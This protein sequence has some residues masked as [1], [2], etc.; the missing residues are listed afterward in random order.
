MLDWNSIFYYKDGQ[1]FWKESRRTNAKKDKRAGYSKQ[2]GYRDIRAFNRTIK[3]HRVVWELHNGAI[4]EGLFVDHINRN[5]SDNRIENLRLATVQE[6]SWNRS[7]HKNNTTG[8]PN[9]H[10]AKGKFVATIRIG[11]GQRLRSPGFESSEEAI[12]WLKDKNETF[13]KNLSEINAS[14][15]LTG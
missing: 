12:L 11:N 7:K 6:N 5:R 9:V 15:Q 2:D 4:P 14:G 10:I 13:R 8:I 1:L 3:E